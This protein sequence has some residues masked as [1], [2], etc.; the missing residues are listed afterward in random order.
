MSL[1]V[2]VCVGSVSFGAIKAFET[3]YFDRVIRVFMGCKFQGGLEVSRMFQGQFQGVNRKFHG[4][5]KKV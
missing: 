2:Y 1:S 5:F 4:C 3:R